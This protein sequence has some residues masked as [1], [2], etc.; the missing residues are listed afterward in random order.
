MK[1]Y[2][3]QSLR[4]VALV[5]HSGAGIEQQGR[6]QLCLAGA[7][8]T[9]ECHISQGL[10]VINLHGERPPEAIS[11]LDLSGQES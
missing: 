10:S 4:N 5:G 1:V 8:M 6:N 7:A 11:S 9:D 2:D 3:A